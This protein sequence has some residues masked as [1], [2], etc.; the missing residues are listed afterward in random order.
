MEQW[1]LQERGGTGCIGNLLSFPPFP[2]FPP[3]GLYDS[4]N[5]SVAA[6]LINANVSSSILHGLVSHRRRRRRIQREEDCHRGS[7]DE[8]D[9]WMG[10][11]YDLAMSCI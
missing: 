3:H 11:L 1:R 9:A 10:S 8:V 2:P 6:C 4:G 7:G 5:I